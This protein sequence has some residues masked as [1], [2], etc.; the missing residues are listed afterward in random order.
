MKFEFSIQIF[1]I[2]YPQISDFMKIRLVGAEV[3][4]ADRDRLTDGQASR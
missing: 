3:F 4:R 1:E 2:G